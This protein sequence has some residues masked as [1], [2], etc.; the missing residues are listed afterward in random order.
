MA[1]APYNY[2]YIFKYIIIGKYCWAHTCSC[3]CAR[4]GQPACNPQ[5]VLLLPPVAC[6]LLWSSFQ[7]LLVQPQPLLDDQPRLLWSCSSWQ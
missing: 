7:Q 6:Y 3:H 1:T 2:S 4:A 5:A